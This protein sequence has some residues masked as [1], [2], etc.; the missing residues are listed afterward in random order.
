MDTSVEQAF[1]YLSALRVAY[2][3]AGFV[4]RSGCEGLS[5][6]EW[7]ELNEAADLVDGQ[8]RTEHRRQARAQGKPWCPGCVEGRDH[9]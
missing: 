7:R 1:Q 8:V 3:A 4:I 9:A 5:R 6:R 2:D